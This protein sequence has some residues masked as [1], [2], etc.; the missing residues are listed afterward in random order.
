VGRTRER[1]HARVAPEHVLADLRAVTPLVVSRIATHIQADIDDYAG[2]PRGE[3]RQTIESA[4]AGG[5]RDLLGRLA[6][7]ARHDADVVNGFRELGR[8]EA[9]AGRTPEGMRAACDITTRE[10]WSE[11]H[12]VAITH[13]VPAATLG[14]MGDALFDQM[15]HLRHEV[16]AGHR[17]GQVATAADVGP[18]RERLGRS[19]LEG[20]D[21]GVLDDMAAR[22]A[23]SVPEAVVVVAVEREVSAAALIVD[24]AVLL[25]D[26]PP[27]LMM[28]CDVDGKE[29][30]ISTVRSS[31]DAAPLVISHPV[32]P[33][34]VPVAACH[35]RRAH[36]LAE[37]GV[38]PRADVVDCADHEVALWLHA[39]PE[40]RARL[41]ARLLAP[42]DA[43]TPHRR[44]MLSQ[45][46]L[47]WL[48]RRGSASVIA[49]QLGVHPQTVRY[50]LRALDRMYG[51]QLRDPDI[52]FGLLLT[53][54]ASLLTPRR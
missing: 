32:A 6:G 1:S 17:A 52:S 10:M 31:C 36:R 50:R 34:G 35:V 30:L 4:I 14:R 38:I 25:V 43:S 8:A 7:R 22:A 26:V 5:L 21:L 11:L 46:L 19:L 40:L 29:R 24:E 54:K 9:M 3:R 42:L 37:E 15:E 53:L 18:A 28:V 16:E 27:L 20:V 47:L 2:A 33:S 12:R 41:A 48:E 49:E 44:R 39:E 13:R 23:W 51:E 45:T